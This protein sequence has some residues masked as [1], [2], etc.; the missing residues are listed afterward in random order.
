MNDLRVL[1]AGVSSTAGRALH[2]QLLARG[3]DV[4]GSDTTPG[5][6]VGALL[7]EPYDASWLPALRRLIARERITLLLPTTSSQLPALAA[8]ASAFGPDVSV[9]V[10]SPGPVAIAHDLLYAAWHLHVRGVRVP[11]FTT[12]GEHGDGP[13]TLPWPLLLR[14][15]VHEEAGSPQLVYRPD[16]VRWE[17]LDERWMVQHVPP[18]Q[19]F[20]VVGWRPYPG[21]QVPQL[22]VVLEKVGAA[23]VRASEPEPV[24][25]RTAALSAARALGLNGPTE[26]TI[27]RDAQGMTYVMGAV[28]RFGEHSAAV[29]ELLD[30]ALA[31]RR[32]ASESRPTR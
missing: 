9:I 22:S 24:D 23:F 18:G 32:H 10:S 2:A 1:V 7:P 20:V 13:I 11:A 17:S 26:I 14:Q 19:E 28:P 27:R 4:L 12:P 5:E 30:R 3:I 8:G 16:D 15:R 29:P 25:I 31:T 6:G 21:S